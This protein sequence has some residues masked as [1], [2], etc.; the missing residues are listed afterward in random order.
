MA[1]TGYLF[2]AKGYH[3]RE[4][5]IAWMKEFGCDSIIIEEGIKERL[6]PQWRKL[7][8]LLKK[9]DEIVLTR[10]SNAVRGIRELGAFLDLCRVYKIRIVSIHDRID[11]KN[12]LF[13]ETTA[14][15]VLDTI[16][17]IS[18]EATK[19]RRSEGRIVRNLKS[20]RKDKTKSALRQDREK[21]IVNMYKS[22]HVIDDIW[23]VS[24]FKSRT[25]IFRVL[26]RNGVE[27]NRRPSPAGTDTT[28]QQ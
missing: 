1:K 8:T 21:M 16:S 19:V 10:L 6:R 17:R 22:G 23:K 5:D 7:L 9:E 15:D 25:T 2:L 13:P 18:E 11:T 28:D 14:G 3:A 4:E 26:K 24:G 27:L 12:E 20:Q